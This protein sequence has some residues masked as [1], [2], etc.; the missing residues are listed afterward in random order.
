MT[1]LLHIYK[2]FYPDTTGGVEQVI[3]NLALFKPNPDD[4]HT[5]MT[6]TAKK[7]HSNYVDNLQVHYYQY[8]ANI[9]STPLSVSFLKNFLTHAKQADILHFHYPWPFA[10]LCYALSHIKK[11]I[12]LTYHSDIVKQRYLNQCYQVL[13]KYFFRYVDAI[14]CTSQP[15]LQSSKDLLPYRHKCH[16]IPLGTEADATITPAVLARAQYWK[17]KLSKPFVLFV[18]VL[19]YYKGLHYLIEAA[20]TCECD[21]VI[22]GSGPMEKALQEQARALQCDNIKFTGY[23]SDVDKKALLSLCHALVLPS[24]LRSEAFGICLLEAMSF[25]KPLITCDINTGTSF[26]NQH[27]ETGI[28]V[29]PMSPA[30]LSHAI[31]QLIQ[32]EN[33]RI[34]MGKNALQR[35]NTHFTAKE[36]SQ[37]Y[38]E[39]YARI[40]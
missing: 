34:Q 2:S 39:L 12:I 8:Q 10:D 29:P 4:T 24:H 38:H 15:Y 27:G 37:K 1:N 23:V 6:C 26:V 3:K 18:G 5:L 9:A 40:C 36:M 33:L 25:S 17:P 11:P 16:V 20:K 22:A 13:R 19:R 7:T 28:V 32:N 14:V 31:N 35:F 30:A 21:I